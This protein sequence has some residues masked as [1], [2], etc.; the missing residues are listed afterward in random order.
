M[1]GPADRDD[2]PSAK[3]LLGAD[4]AGQ[5]F[6]RYEVVRLLGSGGMGD[7][8]EARHVD[9]DKRVA[10]KVLNRKTATSKVY[11]ERFLREGRIVAKL[12]HPH[13]VAVSDVGTE[14]GKPYLVMEFLTGTDLSVSLEERG[15]LP[16][17]EAIDLIL[18]VLA[19]LDVAHRMGLVHRDLKPA[20]IFLA[21]AAHGGVHPKLLDFGIA[22]PN[23]DEVAALTGTGEVF[24][25]PQYMAP[26]QVRRSRD[27]TA[28]SDQYSMA[29]LLYRCLT[30][31]EAFE[32]GDSSVYEL[33]ER[34]VSG[35]FSPPRSKGV[36]LPAQL[37]AVIVR[38]MSRAPA[39]RYPSVKAFGAAL[40]PFASPTARHIWTPAFA[41][42]GADAETIA[43]AAGFAKVE[44]Q[45]D[46]VVASSSA[47]TPPAL[48]GAG[49]LV[50]A[51]RDLSRA[52]PATGGFRGLK[53]RTLALGALGTVIGV[54]LMALVVSTL[55]RGPRDTTTTLVNDAAPAPTTADR[56]AET[57]A[58]LAPP[59]VQPADPPTSTASATSAPSPT[60]S[61][62]APPTAPPRTTAR[63]AEGRPAS[64][65]SAAPKA[66]ATPAETV[67]R[68][69]DPPPRPTSSGYV[70]E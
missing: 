29:V 50:A 46:A 30:G 44:R 10:L 60:S 21:R 26:E 11:L 16:V 69:P 7:V 67:A 43:P 40:L 1:S 64:S 39:D 70:I 49:T 68:P 65:S 42:E 47:R 9:L 14:G 59:S 57:Q 58:A 38:A 41:S 28:Q 22:K 20:N 63:P 25:T 13:V 66:S 5:R 27:A 33:F 32:F 55:G 54:G 18:P 15:R 62:Q 52:A 23:Q 53:R 56:S 12:D 45:E 19:A 3:T 36:D 24:G 61:S 17:E 37:E 6:G 34:I 51:S 8:F 35:T 31:V 2:D 48:T 4:V